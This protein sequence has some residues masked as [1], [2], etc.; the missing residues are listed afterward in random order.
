M[1]PT[2]PPVP[3][4]HCCTHARPL[5]GVQSILRRHLHRD[6][7][8]GISPSALI[9]FERGPFSEAAYDGQ[10]TGLGLRWYHSGRSL[11]RALET[12]DRGGIPREAVWVYHDLWSLRTLADLDQASRR[13]GILHSHWTGAEEILEGCDGLLDGILGVSE[14]IRRLSA[15]H[16]PALAADRV[17]W[18]PYPLDIPRELPRREWDSAARPCVI[19]YCG[20]IQRPQKRVERFPEVAGH[21]AAAGVSQRWEF[22]G[23]GREQEWLSARFREL[24]VEAVFHGV[25]RGA[26]YW[27]TLLGWDLILFASDYEGLPISMLEAMSQGVVPVF[28]DLDNGGRDYTRKV[29]ED[30]LYPA[31]DMPA[32]ARCI[33][34]FWRGGM[35]ERQT[36]SERSRAVVADHGN[37]SYGKTFAR[38]VDRIMAL[39]RL[40]ASGTAA[41]RPH[42]GEHYPFGFINRLHPRNPLRRGYM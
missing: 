33:Q 16:L 2:R 34:R 14:T 22:L 27:E 24:G 41:R 35:S 3:V 31:G 37:D 9:V 11:R 30:L 28:P 12:L 19:G 15:Q 25:R 23:E 21:L 5:G 38:F 8:V 10:I 40:S 7:E 32:A 17:Q 20:R 39:D 4:V 26:Q 6:P 1:N 29:C 13:I 42:P 36:L 18:I